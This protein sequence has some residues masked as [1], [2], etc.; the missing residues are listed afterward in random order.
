MR[1]YSCSAVSVMTVR[2]IDDI[3][4]SLS[5]HALSERQMWKDR[6]MDQFICLTGLIIFVDKILQK[7]IVLVS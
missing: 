4:T 2:L 6:T 3:S 7:K 5:Y 1:C